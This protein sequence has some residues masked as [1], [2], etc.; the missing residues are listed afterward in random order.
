MSYAYG[1]RGAPAVGGG[2]PGL[3]QRGASDASAG[4]PAGEYLYE[5]GAGDV[6]TIPDGV[7]EISAVIIGPGGITA[8][9]SNHAGALRWASGIPVNPGD[10]LRFVVALARSSIYLNEVELF[11]TALQSGTPIG[12]YNLPGFI[13]LGGDGGSRS[14]TTRGGGG[15][16][17]G[18]FGNGGNGGDSGGSGTNKPGTAA[19][20]NSGGGSGGSGGSTDGAAGGGVGPYGVMNRPPKTGATTPTSAIGIKGDLGEGVVGA[21]DYGYGGSNLTSSG[22]GCIRVIWGPGRSFPFNAGPLT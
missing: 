19:A 13:V 17:A 12:T 3:P 8:S 2:L 5:A 18:Y 10:K 1:T 15:G 7:T 21:V 9:R 14:S 6:I 20:A 16:A 11:Y 4:I 22:P